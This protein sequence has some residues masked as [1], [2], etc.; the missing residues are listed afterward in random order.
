MPSTILR[1]VAPS[2]CGEMKFSKAFITHPVITVDA[3]AFNYLPPS[4]F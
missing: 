4:V 2:E 3:T 1:S